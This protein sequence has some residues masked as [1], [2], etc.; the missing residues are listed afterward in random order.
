MVGRWTRTAGPW[1]ISKSMRDALP[2]RSGTPPQIPRPSN[3]LTIA[4]IALTHDLT[5]VTH[6]CDEF[7]RVPG[8]RVENWSV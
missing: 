5:V 7:D 6:N 2:V 1:D 8:L 3:D 4:A